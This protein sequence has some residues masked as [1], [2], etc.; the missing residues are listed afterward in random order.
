MIVHKL[1]DYSITNFSIQKTNL[2]FFIESDK[3]LVKSQILFNHNVSMERDLILNGVDLKVHEIKVD[4]QEVDYIYENDLLELK[5]HKE[6]FLFESIVEID[7]FNNKSGEGLYKSGDIL[8]T[9]NE[10]EGFRKITFYY[11]R[12]DCMSLFTTRITCEKDRFKYLL[13]NGNLTEEIIEGNKKTVTWIDPFKK[14]AYLYA[15]VAGNLS[16]V[17]DKFITKSK[18]EV[19][20]EFFVDPGNEDKCDH[21][22]ES[23]KNAMKWDEDE[24]GLEY[25][26]DI[27]MVVAVDSFNMGAME[28]KGLNVFNSQYVLAKKETATDTNFQGVEAVIGHE[29]FHNWTG[30]RVTC[31]DWFQLTLKEGLTVFR[32][33]EFS[34]DMLD[35]NVKRIE[36]VKNLRSNQF[37]EDASS[38]S[39]PIRPK[40]YSEINNFYTATIYE[41]GAEVIRMIHTLLGKERFRKGMDLYFKRHDGEAVTTE[42]FI[43]AMAD[44]SQ[45]KLDHF[46]VWYDQSGTPEVTIIKEYNKESRKLKVL[47]SQQANLNNKNYNCLYIPLNTALFS[48]KQKVYDELVILDTPSKKIEFENVDE[49]FFLSVN[50]GFSAPINLKMKEAPKTLLKQFSLDDDGFNRYEALNK[51]NNFIIDEYISNRDVELDEY[52][53]TLKQVL[54]DKNLN[55]AFKA[56]LLTLPSY[57][58]V[59]KRQTCMQIE[60]TFD[61]C[62]KLKSKIAK[63]LNEEFLSAYKELN[64]KDSFSLDSKSMGKRALK[65]KVLSYLSLDDD[66]KAL[67]KDQFFEATSMTDELA[68]FKVLY[69]NYNDDEALNNFFDRWQDD[70]LVIQK[71][72]AIISM[73]PSISVED[74]RKLEKN[75]CFDIKVPNLARSILT[76]FSRE[77]LKVA[78]SEEGIDY[79]FEKIY[80]IDR[81]NPQIAAG[82][83][84]SFQVINKLPLFYRDYIKSKVILKNKSKD[85]FEVLNSITK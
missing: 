79:I 13:S 9:Q 77:N 75:P 31:R 4:G 64:E 70:T 53:A 69:Y 68:A 16:K 56:Y 21:A 43:K 45:V 74:L 48:N 84:K 80:E 72:F 81:F 2:H 67:C 65:N 3:V 27:Y 62:K 40:E 42:D 20:L 25:D 63:E 83:A 32:D 23:L 18:R 26:L 59:L 47:L 73:N 60:E 24:F 44:A 10:A 12:P 15:L 6:S 71:W 28:N 22:I 30:N 54:W 33:Q 19:A 78:I 36:D 76:H 57:T 49:D 51:Y 34:A 8:C 61:A 11:D 17:S 39:H 5:V 1:K 46:K 50:R 58:E 37:L 85:L 29:Y 66:Y 7:P 38:L 55:Y 41:K 35:R 14:P 82:I 52:F